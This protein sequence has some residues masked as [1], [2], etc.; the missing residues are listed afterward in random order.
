VRTHAAEANV[1]GV[2]LDVN[3]MP[4]AID[5]LTLTAAMAYNRARYDSFPNAPCGNGQTIAQGCD[6][7]FSPVTQRYSAQDLTGR[8]LVRAPDFSGYIGF[9]QELSVGSDKILT[10]GGG[11]NYMDE[12]LPSWSTCQA[13]PRT[14]SSP[15][16]PLSAADTTWSSPDR[17]E[18]GNELTRTGA[19][20]ECPERN[21]LWRPGIGRRQSWPRG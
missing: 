1:R 13:M 14:R 18:L 8:S 17:V 7:L 2:D 20:T 9:N 4:A 3:Y 11:A 19:S 6:Q 10:F 21:R 16:Q 15:I 12:T 5:G